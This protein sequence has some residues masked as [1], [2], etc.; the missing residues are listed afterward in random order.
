MNAKL[1]DG[2]APEVAKKKPYSEKADVWSVGTIF[3]QMVTL[4]DLRYKDQGKF[5]LSKLPPG[6][7]GDIIRSTLNEN[8]DLRPSG[9]EIIQAAMTPFLQPLADRALRP[10]R[11]TSQVSQIL[12]VSLVSHELAFRRKRRIRTDCPSA[13]RSAVTISLDRY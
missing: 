8:P 2:Q 4:I 5:D 10:K 6:P 11:N 7:F 12:C 13:V 3:F 1:K 9:P